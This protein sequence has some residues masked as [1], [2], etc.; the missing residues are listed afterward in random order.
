MS[1]SSGSASVVRVSPT[2]LLAYVDFGPA[3]DAPKPGLPGVEQ[4]TINGR[5][6]TLRA[7]NQILCFALP[8]RSLCVRVGRDDRTANPDLR[9]W[10]PGARELVSHVAERLELASN[11]ADSATWFDANEALNS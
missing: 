3:K 8:E 10:E 11:P 1:N 9:R 7:D 6:A 2:K 4:I 5:L